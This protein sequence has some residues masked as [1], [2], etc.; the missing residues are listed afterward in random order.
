MKPI[1]TALLLSALIFAGACSDEP[2]TSVAT[3]EPAT[4]QAGQAANL[5]PEELGELGAKIEKQPGEA[6]KI[7]SEKGLNEES[8]E[9]AI[10]KVAEDP[11]A[12]KRYAES[13][14]RAKA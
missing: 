4:T 6:E 8:F 3:T 5:T 11:E 1:Y 7:L 13:Y 2:R 10:R 14:K 12:S 9:Q